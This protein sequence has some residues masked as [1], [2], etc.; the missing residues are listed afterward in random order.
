M[1]SIKEVIN[2]ENLFD[3]GCGNDLNYGYECVNSL[4]SV[5]PQNNIITIAS[6]AAMGKTNFALNLSL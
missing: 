1:K 3:D 6:L 2:K 4:F 5:L